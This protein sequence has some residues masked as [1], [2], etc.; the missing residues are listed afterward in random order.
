MKLYRF[1]GSGGSG[2][3]SKLFVGGLHGNEGVYT[4]PILETLA[5]EAEVELE[6]EVE[7]D[8]NDNNSDV[9]IVPS[10]TMG[11]RY[12]GVLS[13]GYYQS[14]EGMILTGLIK[15]YKPSFYFE[16]HA[17]GESS[18]PR[19]TN[20]EREKIE[21]VPPFVDL[22][23]HTHNH[24]HIL[25]GSIAPVLRKLFSTR[26]FCLTIELPKRRSDEDEVREEVLVILRIGLR[27][28]T[29]AEM[30]TQL[31]KMYPDALRRAE[32]LF[33]QYYHSRL[34]PFEPF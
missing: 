5:S 28:E 25:L 34:E 7:V 33:M 31:R 32:A 11:G 3:A 26:D 27:S 17:Y 29:R 21:G 15:R 13:K 22:D 20:P 18:Y 1:P 2:G 10:L 24:N 4:A 30:L 9:I 19:L 16:L 12:I 8:G 14:R 6:S 23:D